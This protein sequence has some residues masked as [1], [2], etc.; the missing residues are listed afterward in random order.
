MDTLTPKERSRR[1]SLIRSKDTKPEVQLR[2]ML[3]AEGYRFRLHRRDLPG[4]PDIVF[5]SRRKAILVH[6]CFWHAHEGCKTANI[7]KTR[8]DYW[9][10]KFARN[11]ARDMENES[12]LH[13]LGWQTLV[14][15]ECEINE[16]AK[17][18]RTVVAFLGS[19]NSQ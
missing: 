10:L 11:K 8:T 14:V 12:R 5:P 13:H 3:H 18:L 16:K 15:W 2:S 6:G 7:P 17:L 19:K 9:Q 1:M 4:A